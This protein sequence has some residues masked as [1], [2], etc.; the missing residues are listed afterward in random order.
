MIVVAPGY[1][2]NSLLDSLRLTSVIF[3]AETDYL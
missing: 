1:G 2:G 3:K